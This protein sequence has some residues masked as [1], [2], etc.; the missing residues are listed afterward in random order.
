LAVRLYLLFH[1]G[2]WA[3]GTKLGEFCSRTC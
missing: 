3:W 2:R 1:E